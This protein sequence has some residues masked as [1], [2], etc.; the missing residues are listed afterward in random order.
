MATSIHGK[1]NLYV[2]SSLGSRYLSLYFRKKMTIRYGTLAFYA[3]SLCT[4]HVVNFALSHF[5]FY[6][7]PRY[8]VRTT[9]MQGKIRSFK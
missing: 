3:F 7:H 8:A 2:S 1:G 4:L 5:E 9:E 6:K